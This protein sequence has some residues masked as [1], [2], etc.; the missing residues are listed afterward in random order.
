[1]SIME[2]HRETIERLANEMVN[3]GM[4]H[5]AKELLGL[6]DQPQISF[7][8]SW[9]Q[10]VAEARGAGDANAAPNY[11]DPV[12]IQ[13][14]KIGEARGLI[15]GLVR[16]N[17]ICTMKFA[18]DFDSSQRKKGALSC[19]HEIQGDLIDA[20]ADL[21]DLKKAAGLLSGEADE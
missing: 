9:K 3:E 16:A 10:A 11:Q 5:Q 12:L 21:H 19:A 2:Q 8:D 18:P 4:H 13:A 14:L 6:L 1:M 20:R 15:K 17:T 7:K